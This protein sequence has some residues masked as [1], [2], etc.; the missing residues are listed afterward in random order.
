M[1]LKGELKSGVIINFITI[2]SSVAIKLVIWG[3]LARLLTPEQ[4]GIVAVVAVFTAF[5]ELLSNMGIGPAVIQSRELSDDDNSSIFNFTFFL[6]LIF[7]FSFYNF[8]YLIA[9]CYENQEYIKIGKYLSISVF[10]HSLSIVPMSL[11]RKRSEFKKVG[12]IGVSSDLIVGAITVV[13]AYRGMGY[14]V[15]VWKSILG[16]LYIFIFSFFFSGLK[17]KLFFD[18]KPIKKIAGFSFYQFMFNLLNY[19]SKNLDNILIGKY[20]GI[21]SLGYYD[22]AY[23]LMLYSIQNMTRVI[24]PVLLPILSNYQDNKELVYQSHLKLSKL[25]AIIGMPLSIFLFFTADEIIFILFG[26]QWGNSIPVFKILALTVWMQIILSSSG[27]IFQSTGRTDLLFV[28]G[29]VSA[30]FMIG[31]ILYG[32]INKSLILVAYGWLGSFI[33]TFIFCYWLMFRKI[34]NRDL[35]DFFNVLKTPFII[36]VSIFIPLILI[37]NYS[38]FSNLYLSFAVKALSA[39]IGFLAGTYLTKE[40]NFIYNIAFKK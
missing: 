29:I 17:F 30:F 22:K 36:A 5:F 24:T 19:F 2:Y 28:K 8:S 31:G 15:L 38:L 34:F 16:S 10:F 13:L 9:K 12:A 11:I 37:S 35:I 1:S 27:S 21:I 40:I 7:A 4:F 33:A 23:K 20:I 6:G 14:F 3:V 26:N 25:L 18:I 39:G 32:V